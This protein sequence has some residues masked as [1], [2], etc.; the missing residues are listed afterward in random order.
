MLEVGRRSSREG[1][2][3][4][5]IWVQEDW[6]STAQLETILDTLSPAEQTHHSIDQFERHKTD[7]ASRAP[8]E[9]RRPEPVAV[10]EGDLEAGD[11]AFADRAP[12]QKMR[13]LPADQLHQQ[14]DGPDSP[15]PTSTDEDSEVFET[16]T[17]APQFDVDHEESETL[18]EPPR[19]PSGVF[20][21][22]REARELVWTLIESGEHEP[23][24]AP[25]DANTDF[26]RPRT[27]PSKPPRPHFPGTEALDEDS[28]AQTD[29]ESADSAPSTEG[30]DD[31]APTERTRAP[32]LDPGERF[33]LDE[34]LGSGGSGRV[35]RAHD[36]LLGRSVAMKILNVHANEQP[37]LL[38][39]FVAE[40]QATG[41]LEHPNIVPIYDFGV[42]PNG[43][44][45]YT[46]REVRGQSLRQV[47]RDLKENGEDG[48]D[49]DYTLVQ[50]LNILRQVSQAVDYAHSRSVIHRDLK[51]DN[52][53]LGD[54][55]EVLVMDWGLAR[56]LDRAETGHNLRPDSNPYG[57]TLGTPSYM[58][59]E[60]ARGELEDVDETSDVYSL[61]AILYE[62]LTLTPPFFGEG[63]IDIMWEVVDSNLV[64]P[65]RRAPDDRPVPEE[66]ERICMRAM[67]KEQDQRYASA[68]VFH[69]ELEAWLEGIQPRESRRRIEEAREAAERYRRLVSKIEEYDERV[70]RLRN[71]IG[72][73]EPIRRK[74]QLWELEDKRDEVEVAS[75]RAFSQAVNKF[76]QALAHAPASEEA[77]A[78]LADL[79]WQRLRRAEMRQDVH[80]IF[81][82]KTLVE[83]YDPGKYATH[84]EG[85]ANLRV[86]AEPEGARVQI[87]ELD[88][89][90]RRL[91]P[92]PAYQLGEAPVEVYNVPLGRYVMK[93][94]HPERIDV[95]RPVYVER[96]RDSQI[97]MRLPRPEECDEDFVYIPAG[98]YISGGDPEA[99]NP[100]Q[101]ERVF[102]NSFFMARLPVTFG[103]YLEW[104]N[105]LY[106]RQGEAVMERAP[107][108]RKAEGLLIRWSDQQNRWVPDEV[109]IEGT[110]RERYPAGEGHEAK[111]PVLGIRPEDAEAYC[112]WRSRRDGRDYR[113]PTA[114]ELEKAGRGVDGRRFPW[115]NS[116]DAT[117][118]KMRFS[119]PEKPPQPEPV[120]AFAEDVSPYGVRDLAGGVQEWCKSTDERDQFRQVKGG[121]W[122]Q[123]ERVSH[124]A[125]TVEMLAGARN[126]R[127]GF[128]LAYDLHG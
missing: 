11:P 94:S 27:S 41:Q 102:V 6:L 78:G 66:L 61:G 37:S 57:H 128:R 97:H 127:I 113:L 24:P 115:G 105:E 126:S 16:R 10:T 93:V 49:G 91:V 32:S 63:P 35:V 68:G 103:E 73:W 70:R 112:E 2:L 13:H 65:S 21:S 60:Q 98:D 45:F 17:G 95:T 58:P 125:S 46:M 53:M 55:G 88:E 75:A 71:Q 29:T 89:V 38:S 19:P 79:Y 30:F 43:H 99:F 86:L 50:L 85:N 87:Y 121:G 20:E 23:L 56:I 109:L 77:R 36:R 28:D 4:T 114:H 108:T 47:L 25:N 80:D 81:Y 54:F 7:G 104:F 117:F 62:I 44:P 90:D 101:P 107:Q 12:T 31:Q 22:A 1:P 122:G 51:P 92:G 14:T 40:A 76:T 116:F 9:V 3:S 120:G 83:Q 82:F 8:E 52:V 110:A 119:R 42:L 84:M 118:C 59:P 5:R 100:R 111:L 33:I 48:E 69:D 72:E 18:T 106:R 67:H 26:P 15:E 96:D 74:R 64:P 34:E 123:D 39:R 124:M